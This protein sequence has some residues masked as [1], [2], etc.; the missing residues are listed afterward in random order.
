[1]PAFFFA[2]HVP[3]EPT[4][5]EADHRLLEVLGYIPACNTFTTG[6]KAT[7]YQGGN[8]QDGNQRCA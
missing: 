6:A 8:H 1:M 2:Y 7:S 5:T 4:P 3:Y